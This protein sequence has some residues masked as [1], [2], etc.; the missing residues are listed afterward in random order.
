MYKDLF[1][2]VRQYDI[3]IPEEKILDAISIAENSGYDKNFPGFQSIFSDINEPLL[4]IIRDSFLKCCRNY[5]KLKNV[6][7][8]TRLWFYQ[9]W[10]DNPHRDGQYW[11]NHPVTLYGLSGILYLTLPN[12]SSTTGFSLNA[13]SKIIG[14]YN[15]LPNMVYLPRILNKWFI[16]PNW[17]PHF[18]G[19]CETEKRRITVGADYWVI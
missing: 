11:H 8:N 6:E 15:T 17:Y 12:N 9:D 1:L 14:S 10:K 16:F 2:G 18:P 3:D 7:E 5:F 4:E 19:K 13:D